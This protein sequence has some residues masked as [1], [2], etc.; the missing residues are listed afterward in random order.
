MDV[1]ASH[2][3]QRCT[4][5]HI[6]ISTWFASS[7]RFEVKY[8]EIKVAMVFTP[9]LAEDPRKRAGDSFNNYYSLKLG[10]A[11]LGITYL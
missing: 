8:V 5:H 2:R 10:G 6:R 4:V 11:T 1:F 9:E 7:D 3:G